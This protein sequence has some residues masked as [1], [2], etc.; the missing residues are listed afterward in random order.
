[1]EKAAEQGSDCQ[2]NNPENAFS[3]SL[4]NHSPDFEFSTQNCGL[5]SLP[6]NGVILTYCSARKSSSSHTQLTGNC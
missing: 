4:D 1:M 5:R 6:R 2:M 3:H